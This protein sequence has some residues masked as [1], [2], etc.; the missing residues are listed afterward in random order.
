[1]FELVFKL[2]AT[3]HD[4]ELRYEYG[5][6]MKSSRSAFPLFLSVFVA[7]WLDQL[8][9][10]IFVQVFTATLLILFAH[11]CSTTSQLILIYRFSQA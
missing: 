2:G 5:L 1:M 9:L 10:L 7:Y 3:N 8:S 4:I 11:R 6:N